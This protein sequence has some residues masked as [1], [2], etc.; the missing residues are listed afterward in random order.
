[1]NDPLL[2]VRELKTYFPARAGVLKAVDGVSLSVTK[3]E[4]LGLVGE[5]GSGKSVLGLSLVGLIDPPGKI[6][7]GE[8]LFQDRDLRSINE[9]EMRCIRGREIAMVLQD[10]M[11]SLNPV[12]TIGT[13]MFEA[14]FAHQPISEAAAR[15]RIL[16]VLEQVGLPSPMDSL[17]TYPHEFSGGMRQRVATAIALLHEP[18]LIIADEPT[19]ALDVSIQAQILDLVGE[20]RRRVGSTL[21]WITHDLAVISGLAD[22]IAV[23]YSG[24]IVEQGPVECVLE[25]PLH[26]YTRGLIESGQGRQS[27]HTSAW[28]NI[29]GMPPHPMDLPTGCAFAPRCTRAKQDCIAFKPPKKLMDDGRDVRCFHPHDEDSEFS[30]LILTPAQFDVSACQIV[31]GNGDRKRGDQIRSGERK[32]TP[33]ISLTNVSKQYVRKLDA[34]DRIVSMFGG[35]NQRMVLQAVDAISLEIDQGETVGLV[36]ESGSGKS[37]LGR[38]IAGIQRPS[39]GTIYWRGA[40]RDRL[41]GV[42][43]RDARLK[44]QMIFQD[45]MSSLNPRMRV[46]QIVGEAPSVHFRVSRDDVDDYVDQLLS[47]VGLDPALR[48]RFPHQLSGGQRQRVCIAR[49]LAVQPDLLV[50]D[51]AVAALDASTRAQ[52]FNLF[53]R[54]RTERNL[55]YLFISHDIGSVARLS[56]RI[57]V[58]YLGRIVE[59]A[60][61]TDLIDHPCHPYTKSLLSNVPQIGSAKQTFTPLSGEIPSPFSSPSGCHFH[62][63]CRFARERCCREAPQIRKVGQRHYSACHFDEPSS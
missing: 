57:A 1:M 31:G 60:K 4:V 59:I 23:M 12:L 41:V 6:V 25:R 58:M 15:A 11:T 38:L 33:L 50:C 40:V 9:Q 44:V 55:S 35:Q 3:G 20:L 37:T 13:Q 28:P 19:T 53:I 61:A 18:A 36:G 43:A 51:E 16:E 45:T 7:G 8:I 63:R 62:P 56:H 49:S 52:I 42:A 10:P 21:I 34:A 32:A 14:I 47:Q 24:Q 54:L 5:T 22:R 26:P 48:N 46:S 39:S 30:R 29:P 2:R 27:R 17:R